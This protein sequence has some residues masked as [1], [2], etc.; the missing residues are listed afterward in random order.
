MTLTELEYTEKRMR[1]KWY[2]LV[3]EEQ[4]GTSVQALERMFNAYM[5]TV[6]EYNRCFEEY[7]REHQDY[8]LS[9][10]VQ[11]RKAS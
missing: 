1:Q 4:K 3:M 6:E 7:Q 8:P 5:L 9:V 10:P 2:D 11:K